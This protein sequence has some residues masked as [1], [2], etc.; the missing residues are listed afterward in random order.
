[1]PGVEAEWVGRSGGIEERVSATQ[2][3]RFRAVPVEGWPRKRGPRQLYVA[4]K[5]AFGVG[6]SV[7][8]L[9]RFR[10]DVVFGVGGYVSLP[11]GLAAQRL[12]VPVVLHEQNKRLGMAN[13]VLAPRAARMFLSYPD[14]LGNFPRDR[15]RVTGNPVRSA[16]LN[17]PPREDACTR[18]N[19]KPRI[20]AVLVCGGS[21]GARSVN[22]AT[23]DAIPMFG[24]NEAQF[25]WMTG[26]TSHAECVRAA[27]E[28]PEDGPFVQVH[29]FIDDMASACVAADLIIGRA[30]ASTIAELTILGKP[31]ILVPFPNAA[32]NH[33]EANARALEAEDAAV[34]LNDS[35]CTGAR[36][37]ELM[38]GVL[39]DP[40]RLAQ[41]AEASARLAQPGAAETI[42][43]AIIALKD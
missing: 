8:H 42:A 7:L 5:L 22:N 40:A 36:L 41:M 27:A 1:V 31:S 19:L 17:P 6:A 23:R 16:F 43:D 9:L 33:Q 10:P 15:A 37:A 13:R 4:A 29:E 12:G 34:V 39:G 38:R 3:V 2:G 30:G 18:F 20:P 26:R 32:E 11:L 28:F 14:T 35:E 21:Q 24:R 25:I